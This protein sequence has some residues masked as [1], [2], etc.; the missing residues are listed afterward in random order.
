MTHFMFVY[1]NP[2]TN[3]C[4]IT[5]LEIENQGMGKELIE[6]GYIHTSTIDARACIEFLFNCDKEY[7]YN[8]IKSFL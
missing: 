7:V 3:D 6:N 2:T 8:Q 1:Y 4:K 5:D